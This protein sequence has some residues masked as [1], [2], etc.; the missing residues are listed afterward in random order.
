MKIFRQMRYALGALLVAAVAM[1]FGLA[2][3]VQA[4]EEI[5][6]YRLQI[7]PAK[8]DIGE[9]KPGE[10]KSGSFKVQ[11]TGSKEFSFKVGV[12][13]YTVSD[14]SYTPNYDQESKYTDIVKW[15]TFSKDTGTVQ[16]GEEV[17]V[18]YK[19]VVPKDVP[20]GGQYAILAAETTGDES[21]ASG[22]GIVAVRRVGMLLYSEVEGE[23]RR[24]GS[25]QENNIP[26]ILFNPPISG[27]SIVEN[28]GNV[29]TQAEYVL[30]VFPLFSDEE[31]YTNEEN[32]TTLTI[33][34]ETRRFN[35]VSWEGAPRLGIFKVKQTVK[36]FDEVSVTEKLVFL[37]PIW[38]LF[39]V[40]AVI[41]CAI[42]W[43]VV[44]IR[45]R[46]NEK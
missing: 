13:P 23:T 31:V 14:E 17:V 41:F 43:L 44:R 28:T 24:T 5:P 36:I 3:P 20:A 33:L 35:T 26:G 6:E 11:N 38:F 40:L 30:Q 12:F 37:C 2:T 34:P 7:S 45:A 18:E 10:T 19:I 32:P 21:S 22:T 4:E 42:A 15:V 1:G 8:Q 25:V 27:T 16:P 46:K 9:L 39:I 29:H